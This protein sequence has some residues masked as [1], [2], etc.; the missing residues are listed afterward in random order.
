MLQLNKQG[1]DG[2]AADGIAGRKTRA[3]IQR[4]LSD[5]KIICEVSNVE[6]FRHLNV[7][8]GKMYAVPKN[9]AKMTNQGLQ[10]P[11]NVKQPKK[12][13]TETVLG[14]ALGLGGLA[15]AGAT[16]G[17]SLLFSNPFKFL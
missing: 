13:E 14:C 3:S 4:F 5:K 9:S 10:K 17:V 12:R 15:T 11:A 6:L 2:G 16:G 8:T 7:T 1:C